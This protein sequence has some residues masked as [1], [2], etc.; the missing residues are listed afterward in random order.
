[1]TGEAVCHMAAI[2]STPRDDSSC[3]SPHTKEEGL[4]AQRG[5]AILA[6]DDSIGRMQVQNLPDADIHG[7][8]PR[9]ALW[10]ASAFFLL[11]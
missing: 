4:G 10:H 6:T 1:M 8:S 9:L 5:Q 7:R 2:L 11:R 3:P